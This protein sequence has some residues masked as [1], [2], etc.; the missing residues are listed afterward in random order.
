M[1]EKD[2]V[3]NTAP[4]TAILL[5]QCP[6]QKGIVAKISDFVYRYNGNILQSDQ[7]STDPQNGRFFMRLEFCFDPQQ[8]P[9]AHLEKEFEILAG[10][11]NA[12]WAIKYAS[13]RLKMGIMVSRFDHC[14][15]DLLYLW[16]SGELK[17]DIPV[18]ISNHPDVEEIV[19]SYGVAFNYVPVEKDRKRQNEQQQL[20][21]LGETDFLVL[22][23]YMQILSGYF[24]AGYGKDI[25]NIHH[26]FLPSFKGANPY[27]QAYD[28][29]VKVIG[30]TAHYVTEDLDEGPIIEQVV[31]N[32]SHRDTVQD[33]KR[34]GKHL[35]KIALA[36]AIRAHIEHRVIRFRN[37]TIVFA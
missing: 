25:I 1:S 30:A 37:K 2:S 15:V 22:A 24:I 23:R 16:R 20:D 34:K 14:L 36:N 29:G 21:M 10:G 12:D 13:A 6:D 8:V 31:E 9:P 19:T 7:Y 18:V 28:R 32:V 3:K 27:R 26:S 17:V 5:V 4:E 33:L 35:E 11:L